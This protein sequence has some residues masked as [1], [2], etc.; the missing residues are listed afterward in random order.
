MILHG[1]NL[2]KHVHS[3]D[4]QNNTIEFVS[5]TSRTSGFFVCP[6]KKCLYFLTK[7]EPMIKLKG[8]DEEFK[9]KQSQKIMAARIGYMRVHMEVAYQETIQGDHAIKAIS[10][11]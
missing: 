7:K 6:V 4:D 1:D 3:A 10:Y 5:K 8:E 2:Y 9:Y 11:D